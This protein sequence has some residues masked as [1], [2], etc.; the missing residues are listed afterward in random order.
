MEPKSGFLTT[1]SIHCHKRI[2]FR[3]KAHTLYLLLQMCR[4]LEQ[5]YLDLKISFR[6]ISYRHLLKATGSRNINNLGQRSCP[7]NR[8]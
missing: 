7:R 2:A 3:A 8:I 5:S 1:S 4:Q 6:T